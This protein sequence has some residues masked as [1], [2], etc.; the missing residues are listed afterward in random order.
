MKT[1][2]LTGWAILL[3]AGLTLGSCE[4]AER[5][6]PSA[7]TPG[8]ILFGTPWLSVESR[9]TFQD[10]LSAGDAFGVL[11]YCVPYVVGTNTFD[12]ASGSNPWTL[13]KAQCWPEVFYGQRVVVGTDGC[14]YD[15]NGGDANDP[16]YWYRD[17]YDT[18]NNANGRL[19]RRTP[20]ATRS[21]PGIP[22]RGPSRSWH[23]WLRTTGRSTEPP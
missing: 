18:N 14:T 13:K 19:S 21:S 6:A 1:N 20:T 10:A 5:V 23:P 16:K 4:K 8:R 12:Y 3:A 2:R 22:S 17:G 9:S 7:E 15:R 11:G